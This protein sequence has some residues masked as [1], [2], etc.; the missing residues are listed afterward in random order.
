MVAWQSMHQDGVNPT[1]NLGIFARRFNSSGVPQAAEFMVNT[2]TIDYQRKPH[3]GADGN[4][5]FVDHL[6]GPLPRRE[7]RGRVRAPRHPGRSLRPRFSLPALASL[8]IDGNGVVDPLTD[9]LQPAAPLRFHR[10][11]AHHRSNRHELHALLPGDI[12][13]TSTASG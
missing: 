10:C 2:Y 3:I 13:P 7:L 9:G 12:Q 8:D 11:S 5:D 1:G 4:G 6:G